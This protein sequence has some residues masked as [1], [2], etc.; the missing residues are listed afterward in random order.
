[1]TDF[2]IMVAFNA[3]F[4]EDEVAVFDED[5]EDE[6]FDDYDECGYDPYMGCYSFDC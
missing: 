5:F 6:V 4:T 3:T 1:M 2:E